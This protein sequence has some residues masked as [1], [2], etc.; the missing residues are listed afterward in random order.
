MAARSVRLTTLFLCLVAGLWG[1]ARASGTQDVVIVPISGTVDEGMAHLVERSVDDANASGAAA[2]VLDVNTLGGLVTSAMEIRDA[3]FR[4]RAPTVAYISQRAYSAGALISL[5]AQHLVMAPGSSIGAAEP[6]PN[7]AKNISALRAEFASTAARNHRDATLAA[8]MVDKTVDA[9]AY[10]K[11]NA[12]LS[13]TADQALR[14]GM[15]QAISPTLDDALRRE[16]YA[17][18]QQRTQQYTFGEQ[19][20]RF[21]TSP[22][23]SGLLLS[24]GML[25]LLI[26]MQTLHGIAGLVGITA[27]GL[28]FGTH[29][30]AGFSNGFVI[31]LALLGILGILFELHVVPGHGFAGILGI[32]VLL[33]AVVL[34]FG[35]AFFFVA[36][37][38]ISVAI[39]LSALVFFAATR[40]FP[41]NA[42]VKR[43]VLS[44][45]QGSDY[46]AAPDLR[47]LLGHSGFATSYLRPAGVASIDGRRVDVLTEGDFVTA[48]SPV[49]VTRVE[50][51]RIFVRPLQAE[52]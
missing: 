12:I 51:A 40:V 49:Q 37:Q 17:N 41:E 1:L 21:A 15:A 4:S 19:V 27:L 48:G 24:I 52:R 45:A 28:F 6:I 20:A 43:L 22:E 38:A 44:A 11:P 46:V 16:G 31:G 25:G 33:T 50:G 14:A 36:A 18:A 5:S 3:L 29:V 10:K 39:V 32:I 42:F 47:S 8:A 2:V 35:I 13:L 7:T 30:Y 26:E 9:P 23:M 34:S